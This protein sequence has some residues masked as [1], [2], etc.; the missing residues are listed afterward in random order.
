MIV[1]SL[2]FDSLF[3]TFPA[4]ALYFMDL[5]FA[6]YLMGLLLVISLKDFKKNPFNIFHKKESVIEFNLTCIIFK[7]YRFNS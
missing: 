5:K 4:W 1:L 7:H 6:A 2:L 3:M